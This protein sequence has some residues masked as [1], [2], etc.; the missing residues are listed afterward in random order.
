MVKINL[1]PLAKR[2]EAAFYPAPTK[3]YMS[4][5]RPPIPQLEHQAP[6]LHSP[7]QRFPPPAIAFFQL[8]RAPCLDLRWF[9]V[10]I[11]SSAR[12]LTLGYIARQEEQHCSKMLLAKCAHCNMPH[13][14]HSLHCKATHRWNDLEKV[15][16]SSMLGSNT[17]S[18]SSLRHTVL[19]LVTSQAPHRKKCEAK[20][21]NR[22]KHPSHLQR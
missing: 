4:H 20:L 12:G 1:F 6:S 14:L 8:V 18:W 9:M 11:L 15:I 22:R 3:V 21:A 17:Q 19:N 5:A 16:T 10:H 7:A 13:L 2:S